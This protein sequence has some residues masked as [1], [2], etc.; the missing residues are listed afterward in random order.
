MAIITHEKGA[1][2]RPA[3]LSFAEVYALSARLT[4]DLTAAE[5]LQ[6][7]AATLAHMTGCARIVV[8]LR[9][10]GSDMLQAVALVGF[11]ESAAAQLQSHHLTAAACRAM[12]QPHTRVSNSFLVSDAHHHSGPEEPDS[13]KPAARRVATL[14]LPLYG[15]DRE[16][17]RD[18]LALIALILPPAR[19]QHILAHI[20]IVEAA[21]HQAELTLQ[22]SYL[23]EAVQR[24]TAQ[25]AVLTSLARIATAT[26]DIK[27]M[28]IDSTERIRSGFG[29]SSVELYLMDSETDELVL[30]AHAGQHADV[31][32]ARR[33]SLYQG[34]MGRAVRTAQIQHIADVRLDNDYYP[35]TAATRSEL[36][37]PIATGGHV[38]GLINLESEVVGAFAAEDVAV[39][40][41]AAD[42]LAGAM[43]NVRLSRRAQEA[44]VL[45][46][47]NR[48]AR[49]LHDS[50]TQQLFSITLTTRAARSHLE[51]NPQRAAAQLE[52]L[53]E[54]SAAALAEMRAL[55]AQ[56]RPPILSEQGLVTALQQHIASLSRREGLRVELKVTGDER[57]AAGLEQPLYRIVQEALNNVVKHASASS[58]R[59]VL[60]LDSRRVRVAVADNGRGFDPAD[61]ALTQGRHFGLLSMRERAAEVGG[62]LTIQSAPG[63][64]T[65]MTVMVQR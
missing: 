22:N 50:V 5:L 62:T 23:A 53:Q 37:V 18:I 9:Q 2:G 19:Q 1:A 32:P 16:Q 31:V 44:A 8:R 15:Q 42:I 49:E 10:P 30:C 56:L 11:S 25:F 38:L 58:A 45:K 34:V 17:D 48:L 52:R 39:L 24:R 13:Q 54:T 21:A 43:E 57:Y 55:I 35:R 40:V 12:C 60:E 64:G 61:P 26:L 63:A 47:R 3:A 20:Q 6:E 4:A 65:E 7:V 27:Q 41:T 33:Q 46:E 29:Y 36:C 59:V 28:V 51:K 14:L